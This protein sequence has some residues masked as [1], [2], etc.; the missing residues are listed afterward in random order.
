MIVQ[1][2][3]KLKKNHFVDEHISDQEV[4]IIYQMRCTTYNHFVCTDGDFVDKRINLLFHFF[5]FLRWI[6]I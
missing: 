1:Y 4:S 5:F 3:Y 6:I 2:T